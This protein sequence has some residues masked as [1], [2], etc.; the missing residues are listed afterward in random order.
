M[1][2]RVRALLVAVV[3]GLAGLS[4]SVH[5]YLKLGTPVG[6]AIVPI[7]WGA[8]PVRYLVTNRDVT[9]VTAPDLQAAVSRAFATWSDVSTASVAAE[10]VGYTSADPFVDDGATVIGF[11]ARPDLDRTLGATTFA[12]E[13]STG[14]IVESDIFLNSSFQW[15]ATQTGTPGRYDVESIALHEVGHLL[16]LSHSAL[17]ETEFVDATRRRVI[18]K[19]SVMFP[20]AF[21]AGNILDR[22]LRTDDKAGIS[23]LYGT[24][25]F[26]RQTGSISG[27][28]RLNGEGVFGA[29]VIAFNPSTNETV[30]AF[31]LTSQ[32]EF[33][34]AGLSPGLYVVRAE[35]LDDADADSFLDGSSVVNVNF[36]VGYASKL[37]SVPAGGSA[38]AVQITVQPK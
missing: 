31:S 6:G 30:G 28:V 29:H 4:P 14:R 23:D 15:S 13:T 2:W 36:K 25:A 18:G 7:R 1:S 37:V 9:G 32:G 35:P 34:I 12:L 26:V 8:M 33:V 17:G 20:I 38:G 27:R 10:F 24:T 11:R 19:G 16:G 22:T 21:P 5:A 3:V